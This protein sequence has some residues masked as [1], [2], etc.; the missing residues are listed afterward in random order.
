DTLASIKIIQLPTVGTLQLNGTAVTANQVISAANIPNLKFTPVANANGS[1]YANFKFT[2][3]DGIIDSLT[4]NTITIDV[5]D[6]PTGNI[7]ITGI[8][9]QNQ[10]LTVTNT[11]EDA[12]GLGTFNYQWQE[13][14]DNGVTWTNI[15]GATNNTFTLSQAQVGKKVQVQV[16]YTDK[17]GTAETVNSTNAVLVD[18]AIIVTQALDNGKGDTE[19][20]L[21]WAIKTANEKAGADTIKLNTDVRLNFGSSDSFGV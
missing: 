11:L 3:N 7:S 9:A 2:V 15:S 6:L 12:N 8:A 14:A 21:S 5:N 10:I 20:T 19:G 1:S 18:N 13:S 16:S 4:A 17:L